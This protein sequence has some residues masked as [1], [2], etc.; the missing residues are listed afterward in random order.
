MLWAGLKQVLGCLTASP[1]WALLCLANPEFVEQVVVQTVVSC[2][3]AKEAYLLSSGQL[4]EG[5]RSVVLRV[6]AFPLLLLFCLDS[7]F[8]FCICCGPVLLFLC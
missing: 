5:I 8:C 2:S 3:Q 1:A 7:G 4:V 6:M